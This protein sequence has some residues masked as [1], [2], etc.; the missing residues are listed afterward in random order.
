MVTSIRM[1][2]EVTFVGYGIW[3]ITRLSV[4]IVLYCKVEQRTLTMYAM[5]MKRTIPLRSGLWT[6]RPWVW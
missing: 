5:K 2:C 1:M 3:I 6:K 4:K